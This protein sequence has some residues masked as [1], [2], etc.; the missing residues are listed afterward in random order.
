MRIVLEEVP[1]ELA[2]ELFA[3]LGQADKLP[4]AF[5][6]EWTVSR[7]AALLRDLPTAAIE[8]IRAAAMADDGWAS[9]EVFRGPDGK[10]SLRGR[11]GAITK[12]IQR[13]ATRKDWPADMPVPVQAQYDPNIPAFQRTSG[14]RMH[15]D[16]VPVFR[17]AIERI[18][19]NV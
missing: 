8:I 17:A 13:G 9:A 12:A 14:F 15:A 2:R 6:P 10:A 11:T 3:L 19:A 7:A 5:T 1:D 4:V 18:E 16:C